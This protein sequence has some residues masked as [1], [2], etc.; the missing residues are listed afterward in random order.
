MTHHENHCVRL[1]H[2]HKMQFRLGVIRASICLVELRTSDSGEWNHPTH[3]LGPY[4]F[5]MGIVGIVT[6]TFMCYQ[7]QNQFYL[8]TNL[9]LVK[10]N[11]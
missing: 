1:I 9:Q 10:H 5:M 6:P 8:A 3:N 4:D 7:L 11:L 2:L